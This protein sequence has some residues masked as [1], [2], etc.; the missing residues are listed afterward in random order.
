MTTEQKTENHQNENRSSPTTQIGLASGEIRDTKKRA[1][2]RWRTQDSVA[3][4]GQKTEDTKVKKSQTVEDIRQLQA[5]TKKAED[6]K[7]NT[8]EDIRQLQKGHKKSLIR[9][10]TYV[11]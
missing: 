10:R 11:I 5:R 8:V 1:R 6:K 3:E 2:C 7:L 9:S 4:N